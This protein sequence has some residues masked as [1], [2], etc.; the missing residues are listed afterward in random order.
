MRTEQINVLLVEDN[1][2]DAVLVRL[3]LEKSS[4]RFNVTTADRLSDALVQLETRG[5]DV[6]L[7]D[8]SLPDSHG[9]GAVHCIRRGSPK[10]PIILLTGNDS[11]EMAIDALDNGVQDYLLKDGLFEKAPTDLLV[12]AIRYAIHRQKSSETQNL[13]ERLETSHKLLKSKNR[14]LAKLCKTAERFVENVSHEFRS[15]LTVIKEYTSLM[16][17]ELLGPINTEQAQ[18]LNVIENRSD[19]LNRMVDDILDGSRLDAGLL[20]MSR[21]QCRIADIIDGLR[22]TLE[23]KAKSRGKKLRF[24]IGQDLPAVYC[25]PEKVGR[26][27]VNLVINAIK[28]CGEP[29]SVVVSVCAD[30]PAANVVVSIRDNGRGIE[31]EHLRTIFGRFKQVGNQS[32]HGTDGFGLGLSIAKE[33][34]DLSFGQL[35]VE[36]NLD[37]GSTFAFTLPVA[38]PREVI[39]RSLDRMAEHNKGETS[40]SLLSAAALVEGEPH[41][42]NDIQFLLNDVL[43]AHDLLFRVDA[44]HWLVV[45]AADG[46]GVEAFRARLAK[47]LDAVNRNRPRGPLPAV[48]LVNQGHWQLPGARSIARRLFPPQRIGGPCPGI[49]IADPGSSS[50]QSLA[51]RS[52]TRRR[53]L[54]ELRSKGADRRRRRR[55]R[56]RNNRSPVR[57]RLRDERRVQR[58][59]RVART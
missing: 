12:R 13:L 57:R 22:P 15:P 55:N 11:D 53:S 30:R 29:G 39:V 23:S 7:V 52:V 5:F 17:A 41:A 33:L 59:R 35:T 38:D 3:A 4:S 58:S 51:T 56:A 45:I 24:D 10:M 8:L 40:V 32:R 44:D 43:R 1:V 36:S 54:H 19:D 20:V 27:V 2:A 31:P 48:K 49:A 28:F 25:D 26:V 16:L 9:L 21:V 14:R 50:F 34:V 37:N 42:G 46:A 47:M 6:A 18:Y